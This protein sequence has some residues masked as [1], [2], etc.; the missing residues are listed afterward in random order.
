MTAFFKSKFGII[1]LSTIFSAILFIGAFE[2]VNTIIYNRWKADF[3]AR[4]WLGTITIPSSNPVLLWEYRPYSER[5]GITTNRYGF[6]DLDYDLTTKPDDMLRIAFAGD[7]VTFGNGVELE[8]TFVHQ[9]NVEA[10]QLDLPY[11]V[12]ALNFGTDGY[13]TP[14]IYELIRTK[15]LQHSPDIVVYAMCMNDF[16]FDQASGDKILYFRKP[17]SF[18]LMYAEKAHRKLVGGDFHDYFFKKNKDEVYET[19]LR[20]RTMVE[21]EG[22]E[23]QVVLLPIFSGTFQTY[24]IENMHHEIGIFLSENDIEYLDLLNAF[25]DS[26]EMPWYFASGVWHPNPIGHQF[27]AQQLSTWLFSDK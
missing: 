3:D 12:Q 22:M 25:K 4:G 15:I 13:N 21:E 9:L 23:F 24:P 2:L 11:Q 6:R 19:I 27:I 20:M 17:Q 18:F 26:G 5:D 14:Q 10:S 16:D 8:E 7:S 1:L